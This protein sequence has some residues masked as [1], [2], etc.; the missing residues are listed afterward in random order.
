MPSRRNLNYLLLVGLLV[1]QILTVAGIL[2]SQ[3]IE[4]REAMR[5]H[6]QKMMENAITEIRRNANGFLGPAQSAVVITQGLLA[7]DLFG[8]REQAELERFFFQQLDAIP[9]LN[10]MYYG[11]EQGQFLYTMRTPDAAEGAFHT[12][13][14]TYAEG[15]RRTVRIRRDPGFKELDRWNDPDDVYDPRRRP[16]YEKAKQEKRTV[17]TD[18]YVFFTSRQPG[19]TSAAPV[20]DTSGELRG[21]VGVDIEINALSRFLAGQTIG[22][23]GSA[24]VVTRDGYVVAHAREELVKPNVTGNRL[25]LTRYDEVAGPIDAKAKR[26]LFENGVGIVKD[27]LQF[28]SFEHQGQLYHTGFAPFARGGDWPWIIGVHAADAD[29]VGP[30]REGQRESTVMAVII[31]ALI[32]F[33]AFILAQK[34]VA[35]V[36]ELQEEAS[37]DGLTRVLNRRRLFEVGP[38][39]VARAVSDCQPLCSVMFDIDNFKEIND[40][41]GHAVGDEVLQAVTKRVQSVIAETDL[42]AR[43][44]GDE[45][46][47][48]LPNADLE[49]GRAVAER[50]RK[51]VCE[52]PVETSAGLIP[53]TISAGVAAME[54]KH[55]DF[56]Y[57]VR[58]ADRALLEAKRNGRNRVHAYVSAT[59]DSPASAFLH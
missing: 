2:I 10:G 42:L 30:L 48:V 11:D 25:R 24:F 40:T 14:I 33:M 18:P 44:G 59:A 13:I 26:L 20:L 28:H 45:F 9:Q 47:L 55:P 29:F 19:I 17:W 57:L 3:H 50:L 34:L 46:K 58:N 43:Y 31:G 4:G 22:E 12:K 54:V 7:S 16:W 1:L 6:L 27:T 21:V 37:K 15:E 36:S 56:D 5:E 39:I 35:P 53:V 49:T 32:T 41:S 52:S 38:A 51:A 8:L 23:N